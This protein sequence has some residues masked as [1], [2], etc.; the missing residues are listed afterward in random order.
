MRHKHWR[1][2]R[3][4]SFLGTGYGFEDKKQ[5]N[6]WSNH[7]FSRLQRQRAAACDGCLFARS[8]VCLMENCSLIVL[9][10][11]IAFI[12]QQ[13]LK[14]AVHSQGWY[15]ITPPGIDSLAPLEIDALCTIAKTRDSQN[16]NIYLNQLI[17][18]GSI[19]R[20]WSLLLFYRIELGASSKQRDSRILIN[21]LKTSSSSSSTETVIFL[22]KINHTT[23]CQSQ[24]SIHLLR[25]NTH[26]SRLVL[27]VANL[28]PSTSYIPFPLQFITQRTNRDFPLVFG[29]WL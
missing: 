29:R 8:F 19:Y 10:N 11:Y 20:Q 4:M 25:N 6:K 22:D 1:H 16:L 18:S 5:Y 7:D 9:F 26:F 28:W 13:L 21:Q 24:P 15:R 2:S 12:G 3:S 17:L 23:D 14:C 27:R